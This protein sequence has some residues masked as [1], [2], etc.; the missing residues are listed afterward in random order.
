MATISSPGVGS[1]LDVNSIVSQMMKLEQRPLALLQT[2]ASGIETKISSYGQIKSA[3]AALYDA[4]KGLTDIDTWR[5]KTFGSGDEAIVKG[6]AGAA[7]QAAQF[8]V[9]V[10]ALAQA[11][12]LASG[13]LA[14]GTAIGAAGTLTLERGQWSADQTSFTG[15]GSAIN[16]QIDAGDTLATIAG[17]INQENAGVS[18][19]LVKGADGERLLLRGNETGEENGFALSVSD[20]GLGILAHDSASVAAGTGATRTQAAMDASV[21]INGIEV[22]SASN[23]VADIVP[24]VTLNLVKTSDKPVDIAIGD[25]TKLIKDKIEAFKDAYN[26]LNAA[27]ANL[28]RYD[29]ASKKA[30]PLQGDGTILSLQ[31]TLRGLMGNANS[32]G[33][34]FS[35]LGL[36][37]QRDGSLNINSKKLED[38]LKDLPKLEQTLTDGTDGLITRIRDFAFQANGADGK[39]TSRTKALETS[40][41]S[42]QS[43][44]DRLNLLLEQRQNSLLKQYQS[45]DAKMGTMSSLNSFL[46]AQVSQWNKS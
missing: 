5:G 19:V 1:G 17:K 38:A 8:S 9:Q 24:G 10:N 33:N 45:L 44:Q 12:A 43:D 26:K 39:I 7:A 42:N 4:A 22:R 31:S 41:K 3:M 28:T 25:D 36:E 46:S 34:Y 16:I 13:S 15:A 35:N 14:S 37:L 6:S 18:A 29:Q 23:T 20:P 2:K 40:L 30:Q 21:S 27:I 32:S 11:Q